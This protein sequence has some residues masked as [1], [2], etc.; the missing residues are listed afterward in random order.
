[1]AT[2]LLLLLLVAAP[3]VLLLVVV[4]FGRSLPAAFPWVD[5]HNLLILLEFDVACWPRQ[6]L[7]RRAEMDKE[8]IVRVIVPVAAY[9]LQCFA[10]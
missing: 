3:L 7:V 8:N 10:K 6:L 4:A 9:S 1:M 2:S 5:A